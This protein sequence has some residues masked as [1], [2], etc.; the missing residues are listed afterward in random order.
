MSAP[1]TADPPEL[2][3]PELPRSAQARRGPLRW[4]WTTG[5]CSAAAAK[6]AALVLTGEPAPQTVEV[7]LPSGQRVGFAVERAG[8]LPAE[9][10]ADGAGRT[11]ES[12]QAEAVVVK[13]GGDDPDVTDSA[14]LTVM[15]RWAEE[16]RATDGVVYEAGEGVGTVTEPGLGLAVGEPA[17]NPVPREN[18]AT[19]LDEVI[20]LSARAVVCTISCPGGE[21]RA[22]RTTNHRLGIVGGISIL[23]TTGVVRPFSTASW[24][25][26]VTQAIDVIAARGLST[27]VL[28]TG[29]RT[30]KAAMGLCPQ[31]DEGCFVEVGD[32]T[33][34]ALRKAVEH[35]LA[36]VHFVGMAGKLAKLAAGV[37]MTH[38]TRS[39]VDTELLAELTRQAGGDQATID[40]VAEAKTARRAAELWKA[41]GL[42]DA[43]GLLCQRVADTLTR[44][45]EAAVPV[46]AA[47]IDFDTLEPAAVSRGWQLVAVETGS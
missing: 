22:R 16:H 10:A 1:E 24:Q 38:Y 2:V 15:L 33:G 4:G 46:D 5:A 40:G 13:D 23:G 34:A 37:V 18:I 45:T 30:E 27:V 28:A 21:R 31:L 17:I 29:G 9:G 7:T 12:R 14:H 3:E 41:T 6:A 43:P 20:D 19:A 26:S 39:K 44:Y 11:A 42:V 32:F 47:M 36:R 35:G 25:A 8:C